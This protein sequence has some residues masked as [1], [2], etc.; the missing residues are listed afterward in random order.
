MRK[1]WTPE[2]D[3]E[4]LRLL[5]QGRTRR[6]IA[7]HFGVTRNAICGRVH[8][9]GKP[10][11]VEMIEGDPKDETI[12]AM[13]ELEAGGGEIFE[14]PTEVAFETILAAEPVFELP[15]PEDEPAP[16]VKEVPRAWVDDERVHPDK[17]PHDAKG[18]GAWIDHACVEWNE[19]LM[20]ESYR[21]WEELRLRNDAAAL[22]IFLET[23]RCWYFLSESEKFA[24]MADCQRE[25]RYRRQHL[26]TARKAVEQWRAPQY[27]E[28]QG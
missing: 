10:Q 17:I 18:F 16:E 28:H 25:S 27:S 1:D 15:Y 14:T 23:Y 4:I 13:E 11:E 19:R 9:L 21:A 2:D 3:N 26:A 6:Q 20:V 12:A 8:R 7:V 22:L 5:S 24:L